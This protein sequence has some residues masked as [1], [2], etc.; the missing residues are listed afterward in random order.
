M[1]FIVREGFVVH[2]KKTVEVAG[3]PQTQEASYYEGN[4]VDFDQATADE[5]LHKL[6]PDDKAAR[7]YVL[8][9]YPVIV[10]PVATGIDY[11]ALATAV[12]AAMA[13]ASAAPKPANPPAAT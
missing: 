1:K 2:D 4:Q 6:E 3:K 9:K 7:E 8:S 13:A 12:V 5:H 10:P 11:A